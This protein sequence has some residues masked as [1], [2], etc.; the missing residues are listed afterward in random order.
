M[1]EQP[2]VHALK[3]AVDLFSL[4]DRFDLVDGARVTV[5]D[6]ARRL[7]AEL[8]LCRE[9]SIVP[10]AREMRAGSSGLAIADLAV[11]EHDDRASR[12]CQLISHRQTGDA[13]ADDADIAFAISIERLEPRHLDVL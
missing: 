3:I 12:L 5:I 1:K 7:G 6:H 10:L 8:A 13:C 11:V 9:V 2:A 4:R